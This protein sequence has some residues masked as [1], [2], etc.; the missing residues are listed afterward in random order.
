MFVFDRRVLVEV[1]KDSYSRGL[2]HLERDFIQ[3]QF[4][5]GNLRVAISEFDGV[6]LRNDSIESYFANSMELLNSKV[7]KGIFKTDNP[8]YT[9]VRDEVP[10]YY[11]EGSSVSECLIADGCNIYGQ[12]EKSI[13]FRDVDIL[14]GADV[15]SS[16]VMQGARIGKNVRLKYVILDKNVT[17]RD[18]A[19]LIGTKEHPVIIKKGETV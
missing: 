8:I 18:S 14:P 19:E 1:I 7:R 11:G 3:K 15:K 10:T 13:I 2:V 4:N 9:K 16:I 12:L 5:Q 6:V 17:V